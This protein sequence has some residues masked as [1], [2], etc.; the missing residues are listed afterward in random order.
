MFGRAGLFLGAFL[1]AL[2]AS[3]PTA[4]EAKITYIKPLWQPVSE[5][6]PPEDREDS[7][8]LH[9]AAMKLY[10]EY[11]ESTGVQPCTYC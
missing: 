4:V 10:S 3:A 7:A 2:A 11:V 1:C 8:E 6:S 9:S 5:W